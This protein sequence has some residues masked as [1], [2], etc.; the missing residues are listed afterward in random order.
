MSLGVY[1]SIYVIGFS[2]LLKS[3]IVSCREW[4][5]KAKVKV[6][7]RSEIFIEVDKY[8]QLVLSHRVC[9]Y[10]VTKSISTI[11]QFLDFRINILIV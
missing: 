11:F 7:N 9:V 5:S 10:F 8:G 3:K 6:D 1:S 4:T 2:A